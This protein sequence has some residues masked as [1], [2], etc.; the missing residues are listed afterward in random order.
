MSLTTEQ[1]QCPFKPGDFVMEPI[2]DFRLKATYDKVYIVDT[3]EY[4]S[5]GEVLDR[6]LRNY[7]R[8]Q[9]KLSRSMTVGSLMKNYKN[10]P[11]YFGMFTGRIISYYEDFEQLGRVPQHIQDIITKCNPDSYNKYM[12]EELNKK[13]EDDMNL[14]MERVRTRTLEISKGFFEPSLEIWYEFLLGGGHQ[15]AD[16]NNRRWINFYLSTNDNFA[17]IRKSLRTKGYQI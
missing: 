1:F 7:V 10:P 4:L 3:N 14:T 2:H 16:G 13:V 9:Y 6:S 5:R 15:G 17:S 11:E 8:K 12:E